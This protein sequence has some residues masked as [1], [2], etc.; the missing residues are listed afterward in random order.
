MVRRKNPRISLTF[1]WANF[2]SPLGENVP[3]IFGRNDPSVAGIRTLERVQEL[4]RDGLLGAV[5]VHHVEEVGERQLPALLL[6]VGSQ[7]GYRWALE[8][9]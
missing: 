2:F 3:E 5:D 7:L 6:H 1:S 9:F 4:F 8:M